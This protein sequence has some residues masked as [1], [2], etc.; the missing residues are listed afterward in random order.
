[1][2][3]IGVQKKYAYGIAAAMAAMGEVLT[4][5]GPKLNRFMGEVEENAAALMIL[6][7]GL[8]LTGESM[9]NL[10]LMASHGG[11]DMK[12]ALEERQH[13]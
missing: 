5:M 9:A 13:R 6:N 11:E 12:T 8:G 7:K 10:A 4:E 2:K 1:M 3:W